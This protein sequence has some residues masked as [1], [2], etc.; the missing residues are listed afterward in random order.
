M[1]AITGTLWEINPFDQPGVEEGKVYIRDALNQ[2]K[3]ETAEQI[4]WEDTPA[5]R[6]RRGS[7]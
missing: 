3:R 5:G 2:S 7:T 1:T 6:L 4:P